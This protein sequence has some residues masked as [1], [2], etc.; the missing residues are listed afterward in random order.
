MK[1]TTVDKGTKVAVQTPHRGQLTYIPACMGS[2]WSALLRQRLLPSF[3]SGM[4]GGD[5]PPTAVGFLSYCYAYRVQTAGFVYGTHAVR[6]E[7]RSRMACRRLVWDIV[8]VFNRIVSA[9]PA[10]R[11]IQSYM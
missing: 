5:M 3:H 2:Q 11:C 6:L 7:L 4:S 10:I 8:R 9:K 1:I